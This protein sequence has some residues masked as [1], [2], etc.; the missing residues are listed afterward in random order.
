MA[1]TDI[2]GVQNRFGSFPAESK[3]RRTNRFDSA[4]GGA[5]RPANRHRGYRASTIGFTAAGNEI[6]DSA[7]GFVD[8]G[9]E[10]GQRLTVEGSPG[11]SGVDVG[12]IA[13]VAAGQIDLVDFP[14]NLEAAGAEVTIRSASNLNRNRFDGF[15]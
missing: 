8:A 6:T 10:V 3:G 4:N 13:A 15:P 9:F 14:F 11:N 1:V 7:N 5:N 2:P 12:E